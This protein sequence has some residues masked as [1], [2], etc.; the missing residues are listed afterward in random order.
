MQGCCGTGHSKQKSVHVPFQMV[1]KTAIRGVSNS[2]YLIF[3]T[4]YFLMMKGQCSGRSFKAE[5]HMCPIPNSFQDTAI[6]LCGSK[7]YIMC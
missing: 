7:V 6:S 1:F 4:E 5:K 3:I 2:L